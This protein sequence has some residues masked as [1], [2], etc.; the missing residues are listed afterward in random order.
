VACGKDLDVAYS[1]DYTI[2]IHVG[3]GEKN[4][5]CCPI[6]CL[7]DRRKKCLHGHIKSEC[8][9][10]LAVYADLQKQGALECF[11]HT[12]SSKRL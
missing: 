11:S 5:G 8:R 12:S 3:N 7:L 6:E 2:D 9:Q 4:M 1:M 10:S